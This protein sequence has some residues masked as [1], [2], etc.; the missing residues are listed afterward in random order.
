MSD[1]EDE[2]EEDDEFHMELDICPPGCD[3]NL[4]DAICSLRED[5]LDIEEAIA[6]E[7]KG[8]DHLIKELE[9]A[10]K[11]ANRIEAAL[12][13]AEKDLEDFQ[14]RYKINLFC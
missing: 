8:R 9:I 12:D 3:K 10:V 5:R 14:V 1:S 4:Y 13:V 2:D 6:N 7:R 11:S